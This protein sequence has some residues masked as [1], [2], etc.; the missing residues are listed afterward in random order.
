MV[1]TWPLTGRAE[2]LSVLSRLAHR[3]DGPVGVVLA[4]AAG[5]GKTRLA[6]EALAVAAQRG[7]LTRWAVATVS[8]RALPL[9]AFAATLGVIGP[10]PARL[11]RQAANALLSGGGKAGVLIGVDDAHL[12][13]EL[14]ATLVH[15]LV[16]RRAAN[17]VLTLRTGETA[18]DAVTALWKDGHLARLELQPLS[19]DE[20]TS[21]IEAVLGGPLDWVAARRLWS[22]TRGN[23]LYLRQ[24]IDGELESARLRQ[25]A[26]VWRWSGQP[27]LS[28]GLVELL[29]ARIGR[30]PDAQRDVLEVLAFGEPLGIALLVRLTD[31]VAVEQVEARGLIEVYPDGRRV[32]AR[33][34][35]PL[36]GEVHRAQV[37]ML[38]ARRVRGRIGQALADTGGRRAGDTLRRALLTVE[39]D[40][41]PDPALLTAAVR[42]ATELGDLVLA[43]RS[44]RAAVSSRGCCWATRCTGPAGRKRAR[45]SLPTWLRWPAPTPSGSKSLSR[46]CSRWPGLAASTRPRPRSRR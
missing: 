5:V 15:Q 7:A 40:L 37:G 34:A 44:P 3:G 32:E 23:A 31:A 35:H 36:Y 6:R 24:L 20:T 21:L 28:P 12:L 25:V 46:A 17:V 42:K 27:E 1:A 8:A 11:M 16:L 30:L 2:E 33:L 18:P 14:S 39:S 29:S 41:R 45:L 13:D 9:G 22:I 26:G 4:G 43:E 38:H 10:D 19:E